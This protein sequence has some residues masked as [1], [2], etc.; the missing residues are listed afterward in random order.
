[1]QMM[2]NK[3]THI[4]IKL[5]SNENINWIQLTNCGQLD[6][7]NCSNILDI[8][9][10]LI[11]E[12]SIC[13]NNKAVFVFWKTMKNNYE[14][15]YNLRRLENDPI[16][17]EILHFPYLKE[18]LS[19]KI[20]HNLEK[21]EIEKFNQVLI[22]QMMHLQNQYPNV[23][24]TFHDVNDE[25]LFTTRVE[26]DNIYTHCQLLSST[27]TRVLKLSLNNEFREKCFELLNIDHSEMANDSLMRT[28]LSLFNDNYQM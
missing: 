2:K 16:R 18:Y 17:S 14:I 20:E 13:D 1:M 5:L 6:D 12:M 25:L 11:H 19:L 8:L 21:M 23:K 15:I 24:Y 4:D 9:K 26:F 28:L 3:L 27:I 10:L 7:L 22:A